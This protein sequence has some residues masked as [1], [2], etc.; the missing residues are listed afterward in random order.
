MKAIIIDDEALGRDG[1]RGLIENYTEGVTVVGMAD[2]VIA[3]EKLIQE[4][5]P[6]LVF[7]DVKMPGED[8]FQLFNRIPNPDFETIF[9]T[10]HSEYTIRAIRLAAL[11]YLLKPVHIPDLVQ[12]VARAKEKQTSQTPT[13]QYEILH[14]FMKKDLPERIALS[15]ID[16]VEFV[17]VKEIL[18][19]L[20]DGSYTQFKMQD[21]TKMLLSGSLS[22]YE[23]M[24]KDYPFFR[25]HASS[26][27]NLKHVQKYLKGRGGQVI[28]AD[29]SYLDVSS[30]RKK[31][32]LSRLGV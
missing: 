6:D 27:V 4:V 16:G 22:E 5:K 28:M 1:L 25:I 9:V 14:Q 24:L 11:D 30:R 13:G 15:T 21:G 20:A 32:F 23:T 17:Q 19:C 2:S 7:L 10:A 31:D 18:Y 3:G 26:F 29:G 8:G 12:A